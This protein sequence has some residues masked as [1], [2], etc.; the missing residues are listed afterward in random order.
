MQGARLA[1]AAFRLRPGGEISRS[2]WPWFFVALVRISLALCALQHLPR[3]PCGPV[4]PTASSASRA[5]RR[6]PLERVVPPEL[7]SA[8]RPWE[9][10]KAVCGFVQSVR[11][12]STC[13]PGFTH[14]IAAVVQP[15]SKNAF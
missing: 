1:V 15:A 8:E 3:H 6:K 5:R 12:H 2:K 7:P 14:G 11:P 4:P 13:R 10:H 9:A